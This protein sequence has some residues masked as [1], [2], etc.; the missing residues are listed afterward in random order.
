MYVRSSVHKKSGVAEQSSEKKQITDYRKDPLRFLPNV[1][2]VDYPTVS[3]EALAIQRD[4]IFLLV[5]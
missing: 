4:K 5:P 1:E 3:P 2:L